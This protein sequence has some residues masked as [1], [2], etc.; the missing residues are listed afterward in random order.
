MARWTDNKDREEDSFQSGDLFQIKI[1]KFCDERD[2]KFHSFNLN[3]E[4][5]K[6][7][8]LTKGRPDDLNHFRFDF[9]CDVTRELSQV[10]CVINPGYSKLEDFPDIRNGFK[11]I[12]L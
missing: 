9:V 11:I 3:E 12:R 5:E 10:V 6:F 8:D 7:E 1:G 2:I 4:K